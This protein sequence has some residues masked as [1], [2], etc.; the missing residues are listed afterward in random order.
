MTG[1][2]HGPQDPQLLHG[3]PGDRAEFDAELGAVALDDLTRVATIPAP[4]NAPQ[5][6]ASTTMLESVRWAL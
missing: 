5:P 3:F 4:M 2:I 6:R 1:R